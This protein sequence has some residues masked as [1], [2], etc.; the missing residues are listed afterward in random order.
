MKNEDWLE[1]RIYLEQN[2][3][4]WSKSIRHD[5]LVLC[6][7]I[8]EH[9]KGK[10]DSKF[11]FQFLDKLGGFYYVDVHSALRKYNKKT[12]NI[13]IRK[14]LSKIPIKSCPQCSK[15]GIIIFPMSP[16]KK[17]CSKCYSRHLQKLSE[18]ENI[19]SDKNH[20]KRLEAFRS[21]G[22]LYLLELWIHP[23]SGGGD[24]CC[25]FGFKKRPLKKEIATLAKKKKSVILDDYSITKIE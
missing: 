11:S 19:A 4:E 23:K 5:G 8:G 13:A 9:W 1:N 2:W 6:V 25:Y 17:V 21:E 12:I 3:K 18:K 20:K 24:Y 10:E 15:T 16:R 22:K 14:S 7:K